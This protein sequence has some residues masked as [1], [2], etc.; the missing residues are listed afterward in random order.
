[1]FCL[2]IHHI[3]KSLNS[4]C[5]IGYMDDVTLGALRDTVANDVSSILAKGINIGIIS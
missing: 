5:I 1:M 2:K 4:I 3:L